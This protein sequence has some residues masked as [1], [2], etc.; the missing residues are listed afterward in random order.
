MSHV[1]SGVPVYG[2]VI[3]CNELTVFCGSNDSARGRVIWRAWR[4]LA[5]GVCP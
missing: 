1:G 4:D 5:R 2:K 3:P